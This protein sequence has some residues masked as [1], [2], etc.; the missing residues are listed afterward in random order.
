MLNPFFKKL[1]RYLK[2]AYWETRYLLEHPFSF[3]C[4][5]QTR[6]ALSHMSPE[7]REEAIRRIRQKIDSLD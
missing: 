3:D 2:N 7:E 6:D 4:I 1:F 5:G